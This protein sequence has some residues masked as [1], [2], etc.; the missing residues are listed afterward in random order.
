MPLARS[1]SGSREASSMSRY[2]RHSSPARASSPRLSASRARA[3]ASISRL[4]G[5]PLDI[6]GR[7]APRLAAGWKFCVPKY[8]PKGEAAQS[9]RSG[10]AAGAASPAGRLTNSYRSVSNPTPLCKPELT[11][12]SR[13]RDQRRAGDA[14]EGI[15]FLFD[16]AD[17]RLD[18]PCRSIPLRTQRSVFTRNPAT[19][20]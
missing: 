4:S 16:R 10:G 8:V 1:S 13:T 20:R 19:N 18:C 5:E 11:P 12:P 7:I 15:K 9:D 14:E 6:K 3:L 2:R 17:R